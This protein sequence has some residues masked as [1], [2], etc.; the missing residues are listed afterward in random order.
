[1]TMK[2]PLATPRVWLAQ[3]EKKDGQIDFRLYKTKQGAQRRLKAVSDTAVAVSLWSA[4][5]GKWQRV[6]E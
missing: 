4:A 6:P 5:L 3:W 2:E 1:M